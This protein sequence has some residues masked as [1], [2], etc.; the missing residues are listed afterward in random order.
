M[1]GSNDYITIPYSQDV[2]ASAGLSPSEFGQTAKM[3]VAARL[4]EQGRLSLGQAAKLCDMGKVEF[5]EE[6]SRQGYSMVN[7]QSDD[8]VDELNFVYA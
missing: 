4:F 1:I 5:M 8:A 2:L 6:L 3:A 7:L